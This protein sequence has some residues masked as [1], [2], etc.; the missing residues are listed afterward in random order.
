MPPVPEKFELCTRLT[1][2]GCC[3]G[4]AMSS[5]AAAS[6]LSDA[7]LTRAAQAGDAG[8][9]GVLLARHQAGMRAVALSM[10]GYGPDTDDVV[11]DAALLALRRIQ[12]VRN[13]EA[14]GPWLRAVVRN[15]CRMRLRARRLG[16][17]GGEMLVALPSDDPMPEELLDRHLLQDW[18]WH[19][20]GELSPSLRVVAM[21]RYFSDVSTYEQIAS[22]CQLPIG[23]VRS[24]L[25]QVRVKLTDALSATAERSHEDN[26]AKQQ[27]CEQDAVDTLAAANRGAFNELAVRW[28]PQLEVIPARGDRGGADLLVNTLQTEHE[29]GVHRRPVNVVVGGDLVIWETELT[30]PPNNPK[31]GPSAAAWVMSLDA[32]GLVRQMRLFHPQTPTW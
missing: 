31:S 9:L 28:S 15:E 1:H 10:I 8:S 26:S 20:I 25:S 2:L 23:T 19:A 12:D 21:L 30:N 24:R 11:Q 29:N 4:V 32:N 13:P 17:P 5:G 7:D 27:I 22:V 16:E 3:E 6:P 18:V 14:V